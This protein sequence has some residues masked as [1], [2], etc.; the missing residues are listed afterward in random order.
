MSEWTTQVTSVGRERE[1]RAHRAELSCAAWETER[2]WGKRELV[3][4]LSSHLVSPACLAGVALFSAAFPTTACLLANTGLVRVVFVSMCVLESCLACHLSCSQVLCVA[5]PLAWKRS[6][7]SYRRGYLRFGV[8]ISWFFNLKRSG[9]APWLKSLGTHSR[10]HTCK[11][12]HTKKQKLEKDNKTKSGSS[13]NRQTRS[14]KWLVFCCL[15]ISNPVVPRTW[16]RQLN[17]AK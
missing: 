11:H 7:L 12:T 9:C 15:L 17:Q 6:S 2:D 8:T 14:N 3:L 5:L 4:N 16:T 13:S 1:S 10:T